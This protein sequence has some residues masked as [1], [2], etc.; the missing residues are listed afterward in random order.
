MGPTP[1]HTHTT[2]PASAPHCCLAS[3]PLKPPHIPPPAAPATHAWWL[4]GTAGP[5]PSGSG[6]PWTWPSSRCRS[7]DV[8]Q[9][10]TGCRSDDVMQGDDGLHIGAWAV[11]VPPFY[12][13]AGACMRACRRAG[14]LHARSSRMSCCACIPCHLPC[15]RPV[16]RQRPSFLPFTRPHAQPPGLCRRLRAC[17]PPQPSAPT[18]ESSS[19]QPASWGPRCWAWPSSRRC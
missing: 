9:A 5:R 16:Q 10:M 11:H 3:P 17:S 18:L 13:F 8:M 4:L 15:G 1:T 6:A 2:V 12:V 14:C 7:A 19:P